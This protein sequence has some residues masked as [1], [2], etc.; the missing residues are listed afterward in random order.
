[1]GEE[2]LGEVLEKENKEK[3]L[4]CLWIMSGNQEGMLPDQNENSQCMW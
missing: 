1:M 2:G 4:V 3:S